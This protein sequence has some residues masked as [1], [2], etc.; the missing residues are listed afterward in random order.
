[1]KERIFFLRQLS[2]LSQIFRV[3]LQNHRETFELRGYKSCKISD[4]IKVLILIEL[5]DLKGVEKTRKPI[6]GMLH[7]PLVDVVFLLHLIQ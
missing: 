3:W 2:N 6:P 1:L 5:V 4:D 7:R